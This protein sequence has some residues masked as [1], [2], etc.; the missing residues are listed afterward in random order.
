MFKNLFKW[1]YRYVFL[2]DGLL[3]I[4]YSEGVNG[5]WAGTI[6]SLVLVS[7]P[8]LKFTIYEFVKR[9]IVRK[10]HYLMLIMKNY[11]LCYVFFWVTIE[12]YIKIS[13]FSIGHTQVHPST[14]GGNLSTEKAFLVGAMSNAIATL[15]TYPVQVIQARMRVNFLLQLCGYCKLFDPWYFKSYFIL[16]HKL[17]FL[18]IFKHNGL[19]NPKKHSEASAA[20]KHQTNGSLGMVET[21]LFLV[22]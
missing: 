11:D 2:A 17:K 5:L 8:T 4:G 20:S 3:R 15:I 22:R 7:Q 13:L 1:P 10:L 18:Y 6:P 19:K 12:L 14:H 9:Q 21:T 16:K